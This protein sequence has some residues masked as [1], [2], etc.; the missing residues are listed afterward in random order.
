MFLLLTTFM[1][2]VRFAPAAGLVVPDGGAAVPGSRF[3]PKE[4]LPGTERR[5]EAKV[6]S[7]LCGSKGVLKGKR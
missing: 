6:K 3:R 4:P 2:P 1:S 7:D 5:A